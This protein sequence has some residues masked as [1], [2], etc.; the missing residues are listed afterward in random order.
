[1]TLHAS[2]GLARLA[3]VLQRRRPPRGLLHHSDRGSQYVDQDCLGALC[4]AGME[5]SMSRA[6]N[7]HDNAAMEPFFS[8][9][10]TESGLEEALPPTRREAELAL[11]DYIETFYSPTRR[12]RPLGTAAPLWPSRINKTQT[13]SMPP[14]LV[15][16]FS[17]QAHISIPRQN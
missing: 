7:C 4:H 10:K 5:G 16:A 11:F 13:T 9:V 6:G 3:D 14:E 17:R 12:R 15:S 8:T 1:M 2:L